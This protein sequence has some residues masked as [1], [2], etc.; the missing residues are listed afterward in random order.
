MLSHFLTARSTQHRAAT[1]AFSGLRLFGDP[2]NKK[3]AL[4]SDQVICIQ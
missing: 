2:Y 3:V 4:T 1:S